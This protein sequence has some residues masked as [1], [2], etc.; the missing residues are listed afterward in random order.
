MSNKNA[1][2]VR[3]VEDYEAVQVLN[4][5]LEHLESLCDACNSFEQLNGAID[6]LLREHGVFAGEVYKLG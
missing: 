3:Y 1:G 4:R 2:P 6:K 5:V